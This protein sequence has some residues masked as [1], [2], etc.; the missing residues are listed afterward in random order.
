MRDHEHYAHVTKSGDSYTIDA[1]RSMLDTK[2]AWSP[3]LSEDGFLQLCREVALEKS[4]YR[5]YSVTKMD[6]FRVGARP[7]R[8]KPQLQHGIGGRKRGG[9]RLTVAAVFITVFLIDQG[10]YT[11]FFPPARVASSNHRRQQTSYDLE[12]QGS[13]ERNQLIDNKMRL[14]F[15][16]TILSGP[17]PGGIGN[18]L[19]VVFEHINVVHKYNFEYY[20]PPIIPRDN[21]NSISADQ[22]WDLAN[23][24][25]RLTKVHTTIPAACDSNKGGMWDVRIEAD[26]MLRKQNYSSLAENLVGY[27]NETAIFKIPRYGLEGIRNFRQSLLAVL[28]HRNSSSSLRKPS[29][30][31]AVCVWLGIHS[32]QPDVSFAPLL[33]PSSRIQRLAMLWPLK[34]LGVIHLR[35]DEHVCSAGPPPGI[36]P[37]HHVCVL[38]VGAKAT[39]WVPI[40]DYVQKVSRKLIDSGV[41][42]IYM[43]R[44][45]YIP[46]ETWNNVRNAFRS[47]K[48][49][50]VAESAWGKYDDVTLN[51]LERELATKCQYFLAEAR[52]TWSASIA[53]ARQNN[54]TSKVINLF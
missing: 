26:L 29:K 30:R 39:K 37:L 18:Q 28:S 43:T 25:M 51:F 16:P 22:A 19:E 6:S 15:L 50:K 20:F 48:L 46:E 40:A 32:A 53:I 14:E 35:Y 49:V 24:K 27:R 11:V 1:W 38:K 42:T 45:R 13:I 36:N 23:L 52:S 3:C 33:R 47:S 34:S 5:R 17:L 54:A 10:V 41:T 12:T 31:D 21:G 4:K 44:S 8:G 7:L 2:N 9:S